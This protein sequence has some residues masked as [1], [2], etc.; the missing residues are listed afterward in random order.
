M[1]HSWAVKKRETLKAKKEEKQKHKNRMKKIKRK[2]NIK[3]T[4]SNDDH[5]GITK[6]EVSLVPLKSG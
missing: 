4:Q 2:S 5:L 6:L 1:G 3:S